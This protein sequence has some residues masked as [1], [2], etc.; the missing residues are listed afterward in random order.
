MDS[1]TAQS[2][3]DKDFIVFAKNVRGLGNN[4]RLNELIVET[5]TIQDRFDILILSETWRVKKTEYFTTDENHL[6]VNAGCDSGRRGVGF[7]VN[8]KWVPSVVEARGVS[9]RVSYIRIHRGRWRM[10]VIGVYFPHGGYS[11]DEVQEVYNVI[12]EILDETRKRKEMIMIAG[13]FNAEIGPIMDQ[14]NS[15]YIGPCTMGEQNFRGFLLKRWCELH[16]LTIANSIFPKRQVHLETFRGPNQRPRQIDYI[17]V[18]SRTKRRLRDVYTTGEIGMGSDH[19]SVKTILTLDQQT[20]NKVKTNKRH[21]IVW[22]QICWQT[23]KRKTDEVLQATPEAR[24]LQKQCEHIEKTLLQAAESSEDRTT[25]ES[26]LGDEAEGNLRAMIRDRQ[27]AGHGSPDRTRLSKCIQKE[28]RRMKRERRRQQIAETLENFRR[29][30]RIPRIKTRERKK[31]IHQMTDKNGDTQSER[32]RIADIFAEFYEELYSAQP[33]GTSAV[34]TNDVPSN[35]AEHIPPFTKEE[36]VKAVK[37]LKTDRCPDSAGVKAEMLKHGGDALFKTLLDLYN[38]ALADEMELPKSWKTSVITVIYKNGD[39]TLPQNY[40]PI[41]I[42]PLLY[43]LFSKMIYNRLYPILDRAQCP[44]QAGFRHAYSTNDHMFVFTMIHEKTEEF[45]LNS[46][47]AALDFKKAFDTIDQQQL[48]NTLKV[49]HV[50]SGYIKVLQQLYSGQ[51]AQVKTD[52]LSKHFGISRGTK[53]GDPLSSLLFN[54]LLES[55]MTTAKKDFEAKK[56]GIQ[57]GPSEATRVTNLRFADDV[58]LIG[59]SLAQVSAMLESVHREAQ[60]VGLQLHPD[61]TKVLTSTGRAQ[62]RVAKRHIKIGGMRIEVLPRTSSVKYLGRQITFGTLHEDELDHR[63]RSGWAKFTQHKQ[64]LASKTYSLNDR[65]RF[66][67]AVITPTVLYGA[68]CWTTTKTMENMLQRTQRRMLRIMLGQGRRRL[69]PSTRDSASSGSDVQSNAPNDEGAQN[70]DSD[71]DAGDQVEPWID[72]IRRVTHSAEASLRRLYIKNW[73]E[74]VRTKK[75][76]WAAKMWT[77]G[78]DEKWSKVSIRWN[79]QIHYDAPK[80]STRR[81]AARPNTRWLDDIVKVTRQVSPHHAAQ[82]ELWSDPNFWRQHENTYI[83]STQTDSSATM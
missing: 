42:I 28:I 10:C 21:R 13:D 16:H 32:K 7:L 14:D 71:D 12:S 44:D 27:N 80:P 49:Q 35:E 58:L 54:A 60:K 1:S 23:F 56:Y 74:Q 31:F 8:K 3:D 37:T 34:D 9:E 65:L 69:Q 81:R 55:V 64:E 52:K 46:W 66:F 26:Q 51:R 24:S 59:R 11:E 77:H 17:L 20:S 75:W 68:E 18:C 61:K 33:M 79:P 43:K 57:L 4:D 62:E 72:W 45:Q 67:D 29:L 22:N 36:L 83:H 73:V 53:Q 41:C 63:L 15:K 2:M 25:Y 76:K 5:K 39:P 50:P 48:W 38:K 70:E 78:E 40:R 19:R 6:F 47:V 30:K 82:T